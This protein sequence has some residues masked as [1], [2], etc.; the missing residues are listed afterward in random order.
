M[1]EDSFYP[2]KPELIEKTTKEN[3]SKT[4]FS[5]VLF[6]VSMLLLFS[7]SIEI[8]LFLVIVILI[9]ELGHYSFMKWFGYTDVRMLFVP[10]LGAFVNGKKEEYFQKQSILVIL[11]GPIPGIVIG[12]IMLYLGNDLRI[13]WIE[14]FGLFFL[15]I[16]M[17]N[18]LPLDPLDGGQLL[19]LLVNSSQNLFQLIFSFLSSLFMIFI[20][21]YFEEWI[22]MAFGFLMSLRVRSIQKRYSIHK[23][24]K[25]ED[26]KFETTYKNLTNRNF[27]KIKSILLNHTP[28]LNTYVNEMADENTDKIIASQVNDVLVAPLTRNAS[29]LYKFIVVFIWVGSFIAP[30]VLAY[31]LRFHERL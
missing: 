27:S 4:V 16:N 29:F 5:I 23:E 30:L 28:A 12:M 15:F 22:I 3:A 1:E 14:K 8:I 26:V 10:L 2:P 19:K 6:A 31:Y 7:D 24:L 21:W 17:L 18:L 11:A 20:G 13:D 9:H 25:E